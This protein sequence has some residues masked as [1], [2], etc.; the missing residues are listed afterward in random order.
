MIVLRSIVMAFSLFTVIPMPQ[1]EWSER[2]MRYMMAAFPA[3]GV[4]VGLLVLGWWQLCEMLGFGVLARAAGVGLVP[5]VVTGGIHLDGFADVVDALSSHAEPERKRQIMKDPHVGAFAIIGVC[6]YL[7]AYVALASEVGEAHL[8]SLACMP[9]ISRCLSSFA[10]VT[11][12]KA[13]KTGMLAA[14]GTTDGA[15]VILGIV[16]GICTTI[17][18]LLI[19]LDGVV[20]GSVVAAAVAVL[21]YVRRL[22]EREFGG[23]GGDL[24]GYYLQLAELV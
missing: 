16:L 10:T 13:S 21:L 20:G 9:I 12:K 19:V 14:E 8:L 1:V 17:G 7:I 23:M 4:V 11:F 24:A 3:V 18:A 5:V 2:N 15:S 6:S 22:A